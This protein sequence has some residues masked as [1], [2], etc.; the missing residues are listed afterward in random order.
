VSPYTEEKMGNILSNDA[1]LNET[2]SLQFT[3]EEYTSDN[4]EVV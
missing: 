4:A 3:I 1:S 2:I